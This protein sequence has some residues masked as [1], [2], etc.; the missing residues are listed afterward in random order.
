MKQL[1]RLGAISTLAF[2]SVA[3]A[4]EPIQGFY[5]GLNALLSSGPSTYD[6][7]F[8][9]I[10]PNGTEVP[11]GTAEVSN[12]YVGGG[13]GAEIGFRWQ[14]FRLEGQAFYSYI[15]TRTLTQGTCTLVT[16]GIETPIGE[17]STFLDN[18]EVGF[19]G[20]TGVMYGMFNLYFDI[21]N[22]SS[23]PD[24]RIVPYIGIGVGAANVKTSVNF[25]SA[26]LD[27]SVGGSIS[28]TVPAGQIIFGVSFFMDDYA[29]IQA[30]YRYVTTGTI[31][32]ANQF[33][34][35][36]NVAIRDTLDSRSYAINALMFS[37]NFSFDNAF[38]NSSV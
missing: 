18:L 14:S 16:P 7:T 31:D 24:S 23:D 22:L 10:G 37:I 21:Y 1:I 9:L 6:R 4:F 13:V 5:V 27:R 20:S 3:F 36:N 17:C 15:G 8:A 29:W 30:D 34:S 28:S 35:K 38:L 25:V 11:L 33:F 19:N 12:N 2:N 32:S 26:S